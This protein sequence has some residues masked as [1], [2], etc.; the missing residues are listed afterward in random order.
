MVDMEVSRADG[1]ECLLTT[2]KYCEEID[3]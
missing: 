3:E 2:E 1:F